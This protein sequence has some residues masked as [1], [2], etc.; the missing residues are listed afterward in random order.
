MKLYPV[1]FRHACYKKN[2]V[3]YPPRH[4]MF[5][6]VSCHDGPKYYLAIK[7][8]VVHFLIWIIFIEIQPMCLI[9]DFAIE[10]KM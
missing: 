10:Q 5:S 2:A 7:C 4:C 9:E 3:V 8:K 1:L 6:I